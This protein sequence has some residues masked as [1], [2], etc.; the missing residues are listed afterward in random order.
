MAQEV[1]ATFLPITRATRC[2]INCEKYEFIY[3]GVCGLN[4]QATCVADNWGDC[5]IGYDYK[6]WPHVEPL[7]CC[8]HYRRT[9]RWRKSK[10]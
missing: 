9:T 5:A 1:K 2:C 3:N 10:R 7:H 6:S 4:Q 8:E